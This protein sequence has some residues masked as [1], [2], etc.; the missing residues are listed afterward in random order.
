[1]RRILNAIPITIAL[2]YFVDCFTIIK[3]AIAFVHPFP[4]DHALLWS[5]IAL[6]ILAL[7][8]WRLLQPVD[9][10]YWWMTLGH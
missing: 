2:I 4:W 9:G 3:D 6:C 8:P 10:G 1:M 7:I 5:L